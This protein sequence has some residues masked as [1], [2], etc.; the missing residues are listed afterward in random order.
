MA[1]SV[2]SL[3]LS[4]CELFS[5]GRGGGGKRPN[6]ES[7]G[8]FRLRPGTVVFVER[9]EGGKS[10]MA[11]DLVVDQNGNLLVP[12]VGE[13]SVDGMTPLSATKKIEFLARKTGQNHLSG[14]RIHIN[15]LDRMAVVHVSGHVN[16]SGPVTYYE[17]LTVSEA[18]GAAGGTT[19]NA[20][21]RSVGVTSK[22]R[23]TIV[24]TPDTHLLT[25]GDVINVPRR[26]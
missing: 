26:L 18:L 2:A 5:G 6:I 20:N 11:A 8:D 15:A 21:S 24:T 7:L 23:K 10:T 14:P 17:G 1:V 13:V 19:E 3:F 25:E 9:F 16:G 12:R 4:S 22:G